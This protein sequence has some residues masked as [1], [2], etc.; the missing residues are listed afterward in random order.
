MTTGKNL[1]LLG[2]EE[3]PAAQPSIHEMI[4]DLEV[5]LARGDAVYSPSELAK[6]S[7]KLTEYRE[8]LRLMTHG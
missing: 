2:L 1:R 8:L 7:A 4:H 5:E 6:L 3:S